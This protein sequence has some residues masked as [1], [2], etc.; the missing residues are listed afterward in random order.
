MK[1]FLTKDNPKIELNHINLQFKGNKCRF[2]ATDT[3]NL[4][5][6]DWLDCD[7][8]FE[9]TIFLLDIPKN[10]ANI[11]FNNKVLV[12]DGNKH[13]YAKS[14]VSFD[15]IFDNYKEHLGAFEIESEVFYHSAVIYRML[16]IKNNTIQSD[17]FG[18][19][20]FEYQSQF[21]IPFNFSCNSEALSKLHKE[22]EILAFD[23]YSQGID[24][25]GY[26]RAVIVTKLKNFNVL[27]MVNDLE[28]L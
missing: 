7:S 21:N 10:F 28:V 18:V 15:V 13:K 22:S 11:S 14:D 25:R 1:R 9:G 19:N 23:V 24:E 5:Y 8:D 3:R 26:H 6:T 20:F 16:N 27:S 4:S 2:L 17:D 12:I